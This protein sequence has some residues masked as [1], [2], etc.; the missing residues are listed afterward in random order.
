MIKSG[1]FFLLRSA[2]ISHPGANVLL[3]SI[4]TTLEPCFY[5]QLILY[6]FINLCICICRSAKMYF[7]H[8]INCLDELGI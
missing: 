1:V 2:Q 7:S 5:V 8:S 6:K 3:I 4:S